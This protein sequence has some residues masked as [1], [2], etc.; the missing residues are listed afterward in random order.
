MMTNIN[1]LKIVK[2]AIEAARQQEVARISLVNTNISQ[3]QVMLRRIL[4]SQCAYITTGP[5]IKS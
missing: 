2:D 5:V 3:A 4:D 1:E